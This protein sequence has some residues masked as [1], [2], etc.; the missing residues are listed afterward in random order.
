[1]KSQQPECHNDCNDLLLCAH[2]GQGTS[3]IRGWGWTTDSPVV[4]PPTP[5][6]PTTS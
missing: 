5:N 3:L 2:Y 1:M 4:L 6:R